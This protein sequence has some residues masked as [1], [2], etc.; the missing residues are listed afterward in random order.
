MG[1]ILFPPVI[2]VALISTMLSGLFVPNDKFYLTMVLFLGH[3]IIGFIDDYIKVVL[4]RNL[5]LK[6]REK[7]IGQLILSAVFAYLTPAQTIWLPIVNL[8]LDIGVLYYPFVFLVI[9]GTTN[10]VNLTDGLDGL[11]SAVTVPVSIT[12]AFICLSLQEY[13]L[14]AFSVALLGSMLGFLKFNYNPAKVFM[15]DTGSLAVGGIIAG[16]A[17]TTNNTILLVVIGGVYVIEALSVII[18]VISFKLTGKRV[19]KMSPIHHHF[20]LKGWSETRV[21][22]T[23]WFAEFVFCILALLT[24]HYS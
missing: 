6:A 16:L 10:A 8:Y 24:L 11:L 1:G 4:K 18:Q 2:I 9:I 3:F 22:M 15:G 20:E 19:F 12:F 5:G 21:V 23:F 7:I 14:V 13:S 17:L